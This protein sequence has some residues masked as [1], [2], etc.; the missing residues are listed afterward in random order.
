M[1]LKP[2][3]RLLG[4]KPE[5]VVAMM[6]VNDLW[7]RLGPDELVITAVVDGTHKVGSLHYAGLAFDCR[8]RDMTKDMLDARVAKMREK[9]WGIE[10]DAIVENVGQD[11]QHFHVEYQPKLP[12]GG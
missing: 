3:I 8:A 2:G 9:L 10:F 4:V 11:S 5:T 1:I 6:V 7:N 12:I